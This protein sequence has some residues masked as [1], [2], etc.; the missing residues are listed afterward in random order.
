MNP[1]RGNMHSC[2]RSTK[3]ATN[4]AKS[5]INCT[6]KTKPFAPKMNCYVMKNLL[7]LK[8]CTRFA[9][10]PCRRRG[11]CQS[12]ETPISL[13]GI[14]ACGIVARKTH[15]SSIIA[16]ASACHYSTPKMNP[17]ATKNSLI[18]I[19]LYFAARRALAYSH[20][21]GDCQ[22]PESTILTK[23]H[24]RA[25]ITYLEKEQIH[26]ESGGIANE[27]KMRKLWWQ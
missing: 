10:A 12:P 8:T 9:R 13:H 23:P 16:C 5:C 26:F 3:S 7:I 25:N 11:D 4:W 22:S 19:A 24:L 27:T 1:S 17:C 18:I 15:L 14:A 20:R 21:R 6:M 2:V